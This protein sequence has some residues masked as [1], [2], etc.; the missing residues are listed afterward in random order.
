MQRPVLVV[1][2]VVAVVVV[3]FNFVWFLYS[4]SNFSAIHAASNGA[5]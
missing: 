1:M 5:L 2:V 4:S 3:D